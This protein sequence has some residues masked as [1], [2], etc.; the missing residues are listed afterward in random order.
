MGDQP[1]GREL[2][3]SVRRVPLTALD[4]LVKY[5]LVTHGPMLHSSL[6]CGRA[7]ELHSTSFTTLPWSVMQRT[8]LV[9]RPIPQSTEHYDNTIRHHFTLIRF[10]TRL[11][12]GP[13]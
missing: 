10:V 5:Q 11:Q 1:D 6:P 8:L 9:L 4:Q 12:T 7:R 13:A 2:C 3:T